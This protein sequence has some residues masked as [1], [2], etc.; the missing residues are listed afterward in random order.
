MVI[1]VVL[2][3]TNAA[4]D[5]AAMGELANAL[6]ALPSKFPGIV[7]YAW[8]PNVNPEGLD[9]GYRHGFVMTFES[10]AARDAY[11]SHPAHVAVHPIIDAVTDDVLVFDI[12]R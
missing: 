9:H 3:K 5:A 10:V 7:D 6:A 4:A 2:F 11:L 1:H 8:G 12:E